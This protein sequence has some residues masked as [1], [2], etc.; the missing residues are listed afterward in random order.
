MWPFSAHKSRT[1]YLDRPSR[2]SFQPRL[3]AL[4]DR[5]L[6]SGGVLDPTF[7]TGGVVTTSIGTADSAAYAVAT[8]PN[9]GTANDGKIVAA[10]YTINPKKGNVGDENFAVARYNLNGTLDSSF[11]GTGAVTTNLGT[12]TDVA[13]DVMV[14]PDGKVVA[15]GYSG[16]AFAVVRYNPNGTLDTSFGTRGTGEVITTIDRGSNYSWSMALQTDGKI[17]VAGSTAV[18]RYNANGTLDSSFGTGGKMT[19]P[20]ATS[21]FNGASSVDL[22][23][24]TGTS[25]L[26]PDAG[27]IVVAAEYANTQASFAVVRLNPNGSP[28]TSFGNTGTGYVNLST[29]IGKPSVAVQSD[30][31]I[32]VAGLAS[33]GPGAGYSI[34]LARLNPDGTPDTTFGSA[35]LVV[36]PGTAGDGVSSLAIQTDGKIV[37]AGAKPSNF[38]VARFN[39]ANGSLDTSFGNNGIAV[40][41]GVRTLD[42]RVDV[43]LEPDGRIVVA[44][45]STTSANIG[46]FALARFLPAAPQIGSVTANPSSVTAGSSVTLTAANVAA[47]NPGSTVTQVAFYV[48][49]NGDGVLDAG[50]ALLGYGS[51]SSTGTWTFTFSTTGWVSGAFILFAQAEDSYGVFSDPL[52]LTLAVS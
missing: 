6:L 50:D 41:A 8:Y 33:A 24:D 44:G 21:L 48:D 45:T 30:D 4:E 40:S 23:I 29:L 9:T 3:E 28:D 12:T 34:G 49:S 17:L 37:V 39:P 7:G 11:G 20:L 10:G 51:Q 47:L 19:M 1:T 36:T 26:D 14:Q 46:I 5:R 16:G 25:P 52:T 43:A 35:G 27:K 2:A 13:T 15:A 32:V 31:R 22:A 42:S 38:L 18:V